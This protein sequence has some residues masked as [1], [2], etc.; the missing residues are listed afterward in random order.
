MD[1][2]RIGDFTLIELLV[3]IAIIAILASMLL[4]ALKKARDVVKQTVCANQMKQFGLAIQMY[5]DDYNG[6]YPA[7]WTTLYGQTGA[8]ANFTWCEAIYDYV[9]LGNYSDIASDYNA[10]ASQ[11]VSIFTCPAD[12]Q[13]APVKYRCS[14]GINFQRDNGTGVWDGI[15]APYR[16]PSDPSYPWPE[17][18]LPAGPVPHM[19]QA[20]VPRPSDTFSVVDYSNPDPFNNNGWRYS[21]NVAVRGF[22]YNGNETFSYPHFSA[23]NWLFCD[24]HVTRLRPAE[25]IGPTGVIGYFGSSR[26][27]GIWTKT[28]ND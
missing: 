23:N 22:W 16:Y 27:L 1:R 10:A 19:K 14:Y 25:T 15:T 2:R 5:V 28:P 24:G 21:G 9:G 6:Y 18:V 12:T 26:C 8:D 13:P 17:P 20:W 3:V 11:S 7:M 4:P